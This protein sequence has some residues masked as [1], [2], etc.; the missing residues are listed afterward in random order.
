MSVPNGQY[1][2]VVSSVTGTRIWSSGTAADGGFVFADETAASIRVTIDTGG[3][4]TI[5]SGGLTVASTCSFRGVLAKS[6]IDGGFGTNYHN[7]Q[8]SGGARYP[9]R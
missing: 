2:R 8:Y 6:G 4:V 9:V 7:I 5:G 1:C 3:S